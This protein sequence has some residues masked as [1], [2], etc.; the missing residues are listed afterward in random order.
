[1]YCHNCGNLIEKEFSF[2]KT[3][4]AKATLTVE[5]QLE[6]QVSSRDQKPANTKV[7]LDQVVKFVSIVVGF[8]I[9]KYLG[10]ILFLFLFAFLIGQWFPKWY[11]KRERVNVS[12][13]KWIVW[14]NLFTWILPP[15]GVMTGFAALEFGN[16]FPSDRK[17]FK[18]I[19]ILAIVASLLNALGGLLLS[20]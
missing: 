6:N 1:M 17:K 2:C 9:G 16:H 20:L 12:L 11:L 19:A 3:C 13:V 4:G 14:S 7:V 15:L 10:L 18:T 5:K 8:I